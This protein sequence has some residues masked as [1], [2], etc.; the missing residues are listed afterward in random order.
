MIALVQNSVFRILSS[1]KYSV[2]MLDSI[3]VGAENYLSLNPP[4]DYHCIQVIIS[5]MQ[6]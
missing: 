2:R 1:W 3:D 6:E 5:G 4:T